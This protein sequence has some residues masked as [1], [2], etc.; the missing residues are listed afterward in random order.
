M[1]KKKNWCVQNDLKPEV[2]KKEGI[3]F[4]K[5]RRRIRCVGR[6]EQRSYPLR[7]MGEGQKRDFTK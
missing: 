7:E 1:N 3:S 5:T 2:N 4:C 6:A